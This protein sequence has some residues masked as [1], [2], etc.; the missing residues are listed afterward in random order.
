MVVYNW[1]GA[2]G[3]VVGV[4]V[5]VA[6]GV[7]ADWAPVGWFF[8]G[9]GMFCVDVVVRVVLRR[10]YGP[11]AWWAVAPST[12]GHFSFIP[13]WILGLGVGGLGGWLTLTEPR[14][15]RPPPPEPRLL[16]R[17]WFKV[18]VQPGPEGRQLEILWNQK[19]GLRDVNLAVTYHVD[20]GPP[21]SDQIVVQ[22]WPGETAQR[23]ALALEP[24]QEITSLRIK[25][26]ATL[27]WESAPGRV[28]L[29]L[30]GVPMYE[31]GE[32]QD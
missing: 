4:L 18:S 25:G 14:P 5:G 10:R 31:P 11:N 32:P 30:P 9:V 6:A 23:V 27:S 12:G 21:R 17:I 22:D 26:R 3:V 16:H 19:G 7:L 20:H 28:E 13:V 2:L 1:L 15:E 29:S 8:A 24:G